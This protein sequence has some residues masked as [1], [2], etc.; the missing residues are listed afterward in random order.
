VRDADHRDLVDRGMLGEGLLDLDR[1]DALAAA[2]DHV[3][4]PVGEEQ[5]A[6]LVEVAAVAAERRGRPDVT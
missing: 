1:I 6:V 5:I 3:F 4:D 2:D